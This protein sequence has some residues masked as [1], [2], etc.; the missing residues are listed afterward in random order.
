MS[1]SQLP[2]ELPP[3]YSSLVTEPILCEMVASFVDEVPQ[4]ASRL[5]SYWHDQ[6]WDALRRTTHQ[7]SR[8]AASHGFEQIGPSATALETELDRG[9]PAAKISRA[10]EQLLAQCGRLTAAVPE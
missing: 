6:N 7:F 8:L 1:M 10:V 9:A 3:L 4:W 5:Q 2:K